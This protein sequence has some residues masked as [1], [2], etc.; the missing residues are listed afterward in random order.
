[1]TD[2]VLMLEPDGSQLRLV[3]SKQ[4]ENSCQSL[5]RTDIESLLEQS[6]YYAYSRLEEAIQDAIDYYNNSKSDAGQSA[7]IIAERKDVELE[8]SISD[9][10]MFAYVT[11][12]GAY[13]GDR[14]TAQ[15]LI[16][17]LKQQRILRGVSKKRLQYLLQKSWELDPGETFTLKIAAGRP[18]VAGTDTR[19]E[20]L[21]AD[22]SQRILAP[23]DSDHGKVDMRDLGKL[24]MVEI[25]QPLMRRIPPTAGEP[26]YDIHGNVVEAI[27]GKVIA[28]DVG[29]G[30]RISDSDHNVLIADKEGTPRHGL[31]GMA[32]DDLLTVDSVDVTTGHIDFNG[33]VLVLGDVSS[34]M[35]VKAGGN[36]TV[37]GV[38]ELA[39]LTAGGNITIANGV[40]GR[41][42]DGKPAYCHLQALGKVSAK[43]AQ[44]TQIESGTDTELHLHLAHCMVKAKGVVRVIDPAQRH[45]TVTGG[46]IVAEGGVSARV[47][48]AEAGIDTQ[49]KLLSQFDDL[50]ADMD[51]LKAEIKNQEERL[52]QIVLLQMKLSKIPKEKRSKELANKVTDSKGQFMAT[53]AEMKSQHQSLQQ[54]YLQQFSAA[55]VEVSSLIYPGVSVR[56]ADKEF[57][58]EREMTAC[59]IHLEKQK[60]VCQPL[61]TTRSQ[62]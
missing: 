34:G 21:V 12:T 24:I 60:I 14:L 37:T 18:A 11:L 1:M 28:F 43:F 45:G 51:A 6:D 38:V 39:E 26:G 54:S 36:I 46:V 4:M 17:T 52:H 40:I 42:Q 59:R 33:A 8:I 49:I 50:K 35:K 25:G 30:T 16:V 20:P 62:V 53:L 31:T 10:C 7:F 15:G 23:Q 13:G 9:D 47:L 27:A 48:G 19:F 2:S 3:V 41:L 32:V 44:Y 61:S 29:L 55:Q 5:Q 57:V 58:A 22:A 56:I